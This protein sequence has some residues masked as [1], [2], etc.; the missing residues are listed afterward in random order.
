MRQGERGSP[1]THRD[2]RRRATDERRGTL[3]RLPVNPALDRSNLG[4][5]DFYGRSLLF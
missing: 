1:G 4:V 3:L 2:F 5:Y